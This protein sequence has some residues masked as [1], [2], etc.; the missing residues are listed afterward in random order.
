MEKVRNTVGFVLVVLVFTGM[1][2]AILGILPDDNTTSTA[3]REGEWAAKTAEN[4]RYIFEPRT[5]LCFALLGEGHDRTMSEVS[6]EKVK[7]Y[8][9]NPP[10]T[11]LRA[12][13]EPSPPEK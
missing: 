9:L 5:G 3:S 8:L 10:E 13:K 4:I 1:A 11:P 6:Y 7:D 12:E 2:C